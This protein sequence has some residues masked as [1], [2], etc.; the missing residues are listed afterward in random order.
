[1]DK[2]EEARKIQIGDKLNLCIRQDARAANS[3]GEL[4]KHVSG[5]VEELHTHFAVLRMSAGY[6]ECFS[7]WELERIT[8]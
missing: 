6:R 1:M 4:E 5:K 7:Y 2:M 3:G 8:V